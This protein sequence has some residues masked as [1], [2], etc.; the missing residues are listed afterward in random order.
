LPAARE[1]TAGYTLIEA[2]F[3]CAWSRCV[4]GV[5]VPISLAA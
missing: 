4:S 5:A 3:V 2:L 1:G